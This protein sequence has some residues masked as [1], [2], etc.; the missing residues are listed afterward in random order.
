VELK[1]YVANLFNKTYYDSLYQSAIPF[2]RVAPG[3]AISLIGSIKI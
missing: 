1:L 3:R 2:I